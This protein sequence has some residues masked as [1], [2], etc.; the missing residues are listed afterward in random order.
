MIASDIVAENLPPEVL[1]SPIP[2]SS[3]V[4]GAISEKDYIAGLEAAGLV[5]VEVLN[6]LVYDS[7]QLE[8]FIGPECVA[9]NEPA[10]AASDAP[11]TAGETP[12][13]P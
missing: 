10:A 3:C 2:Y 11:A 9:R 12:A 6:R 13:L 4:A 7:N 5:D 8:S 1:K